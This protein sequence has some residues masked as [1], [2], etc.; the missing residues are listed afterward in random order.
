MLV[1]FKLKVIE[2]RFQGYRKIGQVLIFIYILFQMN[3]LFALE[4][5]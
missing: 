1:A 3:V 2:N 4:D 5:F